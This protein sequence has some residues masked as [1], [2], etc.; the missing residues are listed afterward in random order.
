[1]DGRLAIET[2]ELTKRFG[3]FV[4]VNRV[5]LDVDH[6]VIFGL[7]GPNGAGK[8]TT[9][10]MLTTLA[11][12]TSGWA[13]VAGY[14]VSRNPVEVRKRIG[15]VPQQQS[16]DPDL[17]GFENLLVLARL[18]GIG[19]RERRRRICEAL[20]LMGL[21]DAKDRLARQYSGGMIRRLEI[22]QSM[23]NNPQVLFMDEP[24]LG[25]DP[26]ARH[27]VWDRIRTLKAAYGTTIFLTTHYMDE[28]AELCDAVAFMSKGEI[29]A[30][31]AP[32]ELTEKYR[33][34]TLD[35]LFIRFT[36][37]PEAVAKPAS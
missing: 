4:A 35:D 28:A 18:Y 7:L 32:M 29:K 8:S 27:M 9:I 1:M 3:S 12:P 5:S 33:A 37:K 24:T 13:R 26:L 15:Y 36:G 31:G 6:G 10:K 14:D 16:A 20:E 22:A 2:H 21:S 17:T 34:G 30:A 23:L 11:S 25:L 19:G